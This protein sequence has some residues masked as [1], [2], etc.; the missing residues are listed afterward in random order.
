MLT[1]ET[2]LFLAEDEFDADFREWMTAY[3]TRHNLSPRRMVTPE[4]IERAYADPI[5]RAW[6]DRT[7]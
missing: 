1:N 3:D 4:E 7:S 5:A 6:A 2:I